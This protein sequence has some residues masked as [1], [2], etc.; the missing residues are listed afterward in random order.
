MAYVL[1]E[2]YMCER[3]GYRWGARNG[4]GSRAKTDPRTCPKCKTPYWNKPRRLSLP[5]DKRAA[6]WN[7][8]PE[9]ATAG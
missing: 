5:T 9:K 1:I 2:G 4:T 7:L 6:P 8:E 3:C